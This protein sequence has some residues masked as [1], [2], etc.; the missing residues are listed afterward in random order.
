MKLYNTLN[1]QKEEFKSIKE[2][3][4]YFYSCGPTVY[5]YCHLGHARS[6][7]TFDMMVRYLRYKGYKVTYVRNITDIDDKIIERANEQGITCDELTADFI[8]AYQDDMLDLGLLN[9]DHQPQATKT[10]PEIIGMIEKLIE[11]GMAYEAG[12]DVFYSVRKFEGYGKL[13]GKD[14][15]DLESGARVDVMDVKQDPLD[16]AL[17]KSAK[18]GE[19]SWESPWGKG[20]PGWHIECSAM[21]S[22]YLGEN[23]DIHGGGRDLIFPHHENEI[24]QSEGCNHKPFANYWVHNGFVNIDSEKMSKSLNN[25]LKIRDILKVYPTE[26]VRL[27]LFSAHYRSGIDYTQENLQNS[28]LGMERYYQ[29]IERLE[30]LVQKSQDGDDLSEQVQTWKNNF[31]AFMDDDFNTSKV[32]GQMFEAVKVLN[33]LMD[34]NKLSSHSAQKFID[35]AKSVHIVLG[36]FGSSS[37]EYLSEFKSKKLN[38]LNMNEDDIQKLIEERLE[39]RANKDFAKSDQIRDDLAAKGIILKDHPDKTTTWTVG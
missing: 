39:A 34:E 5:D 18:P 3:E 37:Q 35:F 32:I 14:I 17:W 8:K 4:V 24:A 31:E 7:S 26:A 36:F 1:R 6:F 28:S 30:S 21:S 11:N 27:F 22:K 10:I 33:K 20:R 15:E 23:F 29:T 9:P 16:F 2:G 38:H 25:F 12:G 13:S 19:P